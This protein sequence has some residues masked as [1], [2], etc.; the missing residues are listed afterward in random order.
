MNAMKSR[1]VLLHSRAVNC[2]EA[3]SG[4]VLLL[5]PWD[6]GQRRDLA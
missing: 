6:G 3:G 1:S 4:P 2:V 5:I